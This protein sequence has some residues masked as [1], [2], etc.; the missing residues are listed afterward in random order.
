M[1]NFEEVAGDSSI[2]TTPPETRIA[3]ECKVLQVFHYLLAAGE[4][5]ILSDLSTMKID[6]DYL[7]YRSYLRG[8]VIA[9]RH[10]R[11]YSLQI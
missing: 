10:A 5:G 8:L 11:K 4:N 2:P 6:P 1:P 9:S 3:S 7:I